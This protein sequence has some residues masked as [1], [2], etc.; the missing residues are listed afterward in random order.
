LSNDKSSSVDQH[1]VLPEPV[2]PDL[3]KHLER[4]KA[5]H[6]IFTEWGMAVR[7]PGKERLRRPAIRSPADTIGK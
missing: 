2:I 4:I 6:H 1:T 5:L 7:V 3:A